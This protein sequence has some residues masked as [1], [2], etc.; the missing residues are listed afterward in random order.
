MVYEL[1]LNKAVLKK[2]REQERRQ[3]GGYC[4]K[5]NKTFKGH[6]LSQW[7]WS[8]KRVGDRQIR[9]MLQ[10]CNSVG[11]EGERVKK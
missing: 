10:R 9:E 8:Q 11:S 6:E 5:P 4:N 1:C 7:Q 2:E 3:P